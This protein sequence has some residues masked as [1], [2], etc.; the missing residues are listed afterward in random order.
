MFFSLFQRQKTFTSCEWL[1]HGIHFNID[2]LYHCCEYFHGGTN[3][4]PV[5]NVLP[6]NNYDYKKFFKEKTQER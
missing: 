1:E 2:G 6:N 3:N 4:F 5:S